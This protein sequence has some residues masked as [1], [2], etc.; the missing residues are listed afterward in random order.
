V[1]LPLIGG[2]VAVFLLTL[3]IG[4]ILESSSRRA[5]RPRDRH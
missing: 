5:D 4:W 3:L 1:F 2:F